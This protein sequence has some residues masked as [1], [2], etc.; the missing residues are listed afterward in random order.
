MMRVVVR[1]NGSCCGCTPRHVGEF[2]EATW[3]AQTSTNNFGAGKPDPGYST[4][5]ISVISTSSF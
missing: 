1:Y 4:P 3:V 2:E 5:E